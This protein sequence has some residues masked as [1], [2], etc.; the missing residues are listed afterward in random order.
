VSDVINYE[1]IGLTLKFKPIVFPNQDVQVPDGHRVEGHSRCIQPDA[2]VHGTKDQWNG[3]H[4]EQ[5]DAALASVATEVESNG[6]SGLPLLGLIPIIGRLFTAPIKDNRQVDIVIA[7]TPRVIRAPAILP[8]DLVERNTGSLQTPTSGSLEAMIVEEEKE[9]LLASARRIPT[10]IQV[11]L[12][13]QPS[14]DAPKYVR[15]DSTSAV[16]TR[17]RLR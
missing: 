10:N 9:E 17:R 3:T 16:N 1:Q 5:Q 4:T 14:T 2:D 8:D 15:T 12:P 7:I 6:R 13:D 11:Q